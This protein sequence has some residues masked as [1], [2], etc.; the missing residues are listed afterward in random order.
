[1]VAVVASVAVVVVVLVVLV[2]AVVVGEVEEVVSEGEEAFAKRQKR[3]HK[4]RDLVDQTE[5]KDGCAAAAAAVVD[6]DEFDDGCTLG[7]SY[8]CCPQAGH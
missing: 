7:S 2:G 4:A 6:D 1:M 5:D 3:L 8:N